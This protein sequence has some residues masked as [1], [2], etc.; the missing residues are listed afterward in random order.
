MDNGKA[1]VYEI[2]TELDSLDR[3]STQINDYYA[4]FNHV[5]LVTCES[6]FS[7]VS[8]ILHNSNVGI[9]ILTDRNTI[10]TRKYPLED[11]S[12]L[13][14]KATFGNLKKYSHVLNDLKT[15]KC[16]KLISICLI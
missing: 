12:L 5:C 3:L 15:S 7:K 13:S 16:F 2:K 8:S 1:A 9:C 10:S 4:A 11:N 14:H 6:N